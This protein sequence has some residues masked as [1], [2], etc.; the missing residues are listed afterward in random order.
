MARRIHT[1]IHIYIYTHIN[2]CIC[3]YM[4]IYIYIYIY[5]ERVRRNTGLCFSVKTSVFYTFLEVE[6]IKSIYSHSKLFAGCK[7]IISILV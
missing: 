3:I 1:H 6:T 4:C 7:C 5:R 2:I